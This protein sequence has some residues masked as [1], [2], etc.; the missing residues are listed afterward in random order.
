MN[1]FDTNV[2]VYFGE[3]GTIKSA[4]SGALLVAGGLVSVQVLNEFANVARRK[5]KLGWDQ[6][7]ETLELIRE[8]VDVVPLTV[9]THD[10][11]LRLAS[12]HNFH[13]Y[14]SLVV[15]SALLSGCDTLYSEDMHAGLVVENRLTIVNPFT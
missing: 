11:A 14:D 15:A 8:L 10:A 1:F 7:G 4:K 13:F 9:E 3:Q 6:I 2:L 5:N 12:R